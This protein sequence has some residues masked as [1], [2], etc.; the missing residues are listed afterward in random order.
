MLTGLSTM[1]IA[2]WSG[3]L[4]FSS[5]SLQWCG[6]ETRTSTRPIQESTHGACVEIVIIIGHSGTVM[7]DDSLFACVIGGT[8]MLSPMRIVCVCLSVLPT[9]FSWKPTRVHENGAPADPLLTVINQ[10]CL[11]LI[12]SA[13]DRSRHS[14][15]IDVDM[16]LSQKTLGSGIRLVTHPLS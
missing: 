13:P 5:C 14:F 3:S 6:C 12:G 4:P 8:A 16:Q 10:R 1:R 15:C 9:P 11:S 7:V 2:T